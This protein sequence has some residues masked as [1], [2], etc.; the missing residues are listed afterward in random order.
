MD[1]LLPYLDANPN[2]LGY[3]AFGGIWEGNFITPDGSGLTPAGHKYKTMST[4]APSAM[5]S[6]TTD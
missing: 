2:V 1:N 6:E 4:S 5:A 3:P